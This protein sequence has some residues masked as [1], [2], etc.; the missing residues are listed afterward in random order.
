MEGRNESEEIAQQFRK[1]V[2][3]DVGSDRFATDGK[4]KVRNN[5]KRQ[6]RM[7]TNTTGSWFLKVS[8]AL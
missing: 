5:E 7:F 4:Y 8:Q 3:Q 1:G 6:Q 2:F